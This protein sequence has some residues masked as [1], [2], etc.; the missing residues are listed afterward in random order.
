MFSFNYWQDCPVVDC[1]IFYDDALPCLYEDLVPT[2]DDFNG[3]Q[4]LSCPVCPDEA[5]SPAATTHASATS[6]QEA[7][8]D[9][10][11]TSRSGDDE[12]E[13]GSL[14][15]GVAAGADDDVTGDEDEAE[16]SD[17]GSSLSVGLNSITDK[18][19]RTINAIKQWLDNSTQTISDLEFTISGDS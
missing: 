18:L 19:R 8:S 5:S 1:P 15:G 2:Y 13:D 6:K 12:D 9:V 17:E 16:L 10:T 4:C 7:A 11:T 14:P 3:V